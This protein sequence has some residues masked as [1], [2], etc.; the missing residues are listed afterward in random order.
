VE[1]ERGG[2]SRPDGSRAA[3]RSSCPRRP[4][5]S[6]GEPFPATILDVKL[7]PKERDLG[8]RLFELDDVAEEDAEALNWYLMSLQ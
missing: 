1:P 2:R 4:G 6:L 7:F 3:S 5:R 8:G